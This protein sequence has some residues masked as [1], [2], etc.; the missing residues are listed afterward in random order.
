L[1]D[2]AHFN[3][4]C[5]GKYWKYSSKNVFKI[6]NYWKFL[7]RTFKPLENPEL[8]LFPGFKIK[9]LLSF[10]LTNTLK[11]KLNAIWKQIFPTFCRKIEKKLK[12][13]QKMRSIRRR[14][15]ELPSCQVAFE[16]KD[17]ALNNP[18]EFQFLFRSSITK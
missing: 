18:W 3:N 6:Q 14:I 2:L 11:I 13:S 10:L 7:V 16:L 4:Q 15:P 5:V 1:G 12:I 17:Y 9:Y 8:D